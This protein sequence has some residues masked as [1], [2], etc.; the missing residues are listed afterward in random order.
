[1][2]DALSEQVIGIIAKAQ[3]LPVESI[4]PSSTFAELKFDSLDAMN[5]VFALEAEFNVT[6]PD[7]KAQSIASIGDVIEGIR[8]L[9]N[10][11]QRAKLQ[12]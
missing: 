8:G 9:L 5:I 2:P 7:D 12:A 3:H 10:Q 11:E 6:I 1:M 4:K